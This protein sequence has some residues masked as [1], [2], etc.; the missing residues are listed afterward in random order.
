MGINL[1]SDAESRP[2]LMDPDFVN[3]DLD[4]VGF[5]IVH[6]HCY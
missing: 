5:S 1:D 4:L 2:N 6:V 3:L